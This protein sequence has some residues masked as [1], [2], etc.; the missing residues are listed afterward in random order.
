MCERAKIRANN[1]RYD[2]TVL[3]PFRTGDEYNKTFGHYHPKIAV[4]DTW[5]PEVYEVL[6]G[7]A[8]YLLQNGSEFLVFDARPGD[9]CLMIP[10]FAH[11]TVNPSLRE[12]LV[13]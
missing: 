11:I 10:G 2:I 8:H 3:P 7:R 6:H 4:T 9:K 1:L 5:Y 12:T 13:M